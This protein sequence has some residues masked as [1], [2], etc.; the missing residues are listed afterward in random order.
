MLLAMIGFAVAGATYAFAKKQ[1][2]VGRHRRRRRHGHGRRLG[3]GRLAHDASATVLLPL[4][5]IGGIGYWYFKRGNKPKA[6][7]AGR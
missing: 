6:L 5:A 1:A 2:G 3:G 7:R 4:A